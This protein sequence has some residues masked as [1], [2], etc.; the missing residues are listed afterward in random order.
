MLLYSNNQSTRLLFSS[1]VFM[2]FTFSQ[3][4]AQK[5]S[6]SDEDDKKH[7]R[8]DVAYADKSELKN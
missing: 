5:S 4:T 1:I 8:L 3:L 2:N 6:E 7:K